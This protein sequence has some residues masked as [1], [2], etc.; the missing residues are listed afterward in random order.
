MDKIITAKEA[1][2]ILNLSR[3]RISQLLKARKIGTREGGIEY[4]KVIHYRD[5]RKNGRPEGTYKK[6]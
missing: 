5:N 1:A 4:D 2:D 6:P 3:E